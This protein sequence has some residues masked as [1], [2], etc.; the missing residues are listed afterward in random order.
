MNK[1]ERDELRKV[2]EKRLSALNTCDEDGNPST[3]LVYTTTVLSTEL[4][5]NLLDQLDAYESV[6]DAAKDV[7]Y[8]DAFH[9]ESQVAHDLIKALEGLE[10]ED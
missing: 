2:I 1:Q 3:H 10:D 7:I 4:V 9:F 6:V 8:A 5:K